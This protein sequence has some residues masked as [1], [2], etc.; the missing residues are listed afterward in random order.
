LLADPSTLKKKRKNRNKN[1]NNNNNNIL[2]NGSHK[3][4]FW[5][6]RETTQLLGWK[7]HRKK[8]KRQTSDAAAPGFE[9]E[10]ESTKQNK[11][12][13]DGRSERKCSSG[14]LCF[15]FTAVNWIT[16]RSE[17]QPITDDKGK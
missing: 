3:A 9:R 15:P 16:V 12:E 5:R 14:K 2:T 17:I 7:D 10:R 6:S 13:M 1:N 4:F 11:A 8:T